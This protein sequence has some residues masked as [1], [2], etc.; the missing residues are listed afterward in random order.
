MPT[1]NALC[2]M[3]IVW[4]CMHRAQRALC[5]ATCIV[6]NA[7]SMYKLCG[8]TC[9]VRHAHCVAL[10][11]SCAM[12]IHVQVVWSYMHCV[13]DTRL[14]VA[15]VVRWFV[16]P[17]VQRE[18]SSGRPDIMG[19]GIMAPSRRVVLGCAV[20]RPYKTTSFPSC[21]LHFEPAMWV[22]LKPGVQ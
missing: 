7:H 15:S 18:R 4:R 20:C 11:V 3:R 16:H 8:P 1:P 9:I 14:C 19:N 13:A 2:A 10:H 22:L 21:L 17:C 12:P 5:G 6:C